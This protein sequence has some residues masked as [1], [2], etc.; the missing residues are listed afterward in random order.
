[1][2]QIVIIGA[3]DT[4]GRITFDHVHFGANPGKK[5]GPVGGGFIERF[6]IRI[7][8]HAPGAGGECVV[9]CNGDEWCP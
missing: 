3:L 4:N 1:M 7:G 5:M 6:K 9:D 8:E 2:K